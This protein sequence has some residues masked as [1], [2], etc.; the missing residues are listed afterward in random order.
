MGKKLTKLTELMDLNHTGDGRWVTGALAG[1]LDLI[2]LGKLSLMNCQGLRAA[3]S[4]LVDQK[5]QHKSIAQGVFFASWTGYSLE[6]AGGVGAED[7]GGAGR[8]TPGKGQETLPVL[9]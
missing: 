3:P 5:G 2:T 8:L 4:S 6:D 9:S 1:Q 7:P